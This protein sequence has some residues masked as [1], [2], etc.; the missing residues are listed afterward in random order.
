M[1]IIGI[2]KVQN[3]IAKASDSIKSDATE[4]MPKAL[5]EVKSAITGT[6]PV[7]HPDGEVLRAY[8][9]INPV[10]ESKKIAAKNDIFEYLKSI[11]IT[12]QERWEH[13]YSSLAENG[14]VSEKSFE[15]LKSFQKKR[16]PLLNSARIFETAKE[17]GKINYKALN[18]IDKLM[19]TPKGIS[20]QDN[21]FVKTLNLLKDSKG[22][23]NEELI[24]AFEKRI[25]EVKKHI[26]YNPESLFR[27]LKNKE[28][29]F[30]DDAVSYFSKQIEKDKKINEIFSDIFKAHEGNGRFDFDNIKL[31]D[32]IK[33]TFPGNKFFKVKDMVMNAPK[34]E[35][36][37]IIEMA[38]SIMDEQNFEEILYNVSELKLD[39]TEENIA[40]AKKIIEITNGN[41]ANFNI[42]KKY[43]PLSPDK[44]DK[45]SEQLLKTA[46]NS[47]WQNGSLEEALKGSVYKVGANKDKFDFENLKCFLTIKREKGWVSDYIIPELSSKLSLETDNRALKLFTQLYTMKFPPKN[48]ED[49]PQMLDCNKLSFI[50]SLLTKSANDNIPQRACY[51]PAIE[52]I[53]KLTKSNFAKK[54]VEIFEHFVTLP[55]AENFSHIAKLERVNLEEVGI[56]PAESLIFSSSEEKNI[57]KFKDFLKSY[58]AEN[59]LENL[60]VTANSN[61]FGRV[62]ILSK[63]KDIT[64]TLIYDFA[65][66]KP[67]TNIKTR[68]LSYNTFE[69]IQRD[70]ANNTETNYIYSKNFSGYEKLKSQ[71]IKHF[72][73]NNNELYREVWEQS[74][75]KG[76]YDI[77]TVTSDGKIDVISKAYHDKTSGN[78]IV[79]KHMK[80]FD[81]TKT[82]YRYE[83][84]NA[85]NIISDY[86]ITDKDKNVLLNRS[87][88]FERIDNNHYKTSKNGITYD[89][90]TEDNFI[91][92][93]NENTKATRRINAEELLKDGE[94]NISDVIRKIPG[95]ELFKMNEL[96]LKGIQSLKYYQNAAFSS[97]S[98]KILLGKDHSDL[99][100]LMH[101]WG[102][103]KDY[104]MFKEISEII[105]NDKALFKIYDEERKLFRKNISEIQLDFINYFIGDHH[106]LGKDKAITEGI[107][108]TNGILNALP[109]NDIVSMRAQYWQQYFPKTISYLAN[110]LE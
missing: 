103:A 20:Y 80:S 67:I 10:K 56:N 72:D 96:N 50:S 1:K 39:V 46:C 77:Q 18:L 9:N 101:E 45:E 102:H 87:F 93:T 41:R 6:L 76:I 44:L 104:L 94:F 8:Y 82:D 40:F 62:E 52:N 95:D 63:N 89:V 92:I 19:E 73:S 7:K 33:D 32:E 85:G 98:E 90:K 99:F 38:K 51:L 43:V 48:G 3:I 75:V 12:N 68:S 28:M 110:L 109:E 27:T 17:D 78:K 31:L 35:R 11:G 97:D 69:K 4:L 54:D 14:E 49:V 88:V 15:I 100:T 24:S 47:F 86:K 83:T 66:Q 61:L 42:L 60:S 71:T 16:N 84:D 36:R 59:K 55:S 22:K 26:R 23:F 106:Y 74:P 29:D 64:N 21:G 65:N 5:E 57:L 34:S 13:L 81:G 107:A 30:Y 53:E 25:P 91:N 108:E 70:Y 105:N 37:N 58:K 79:E 2:R